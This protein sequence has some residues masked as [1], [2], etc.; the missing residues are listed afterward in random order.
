MRSKILGFRGETRVLPPLQ[1]SAYTLG[2]NV[3]HEHRNPFI[4]S[5]ILIQLLQTSIHSCY[6]T[7]SENPLVALAA[8]MRIALSTPLEP[9]TEDKE[10]QTARL[11][12]IDMIPD[13]QRALIGEQA[14][15]RNLTWSVILSSYPSPR[16]YHL[17]DRG[18]RV[19]SL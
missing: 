8:A 12:I 2:S 14:T 4:L 15:I 11:D 19:F 3:L 6:I 5:L 18:I 1:G 13:V 7:M 16:I 9:A 17:T 10:G